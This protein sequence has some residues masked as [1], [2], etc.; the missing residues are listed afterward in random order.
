MRT[1]MHTYLEQVGTTLRPGRVKNIEATL[2]EFAGFATEH[3]PS[4]RC[5]ADLGRSHVEAY[6]C[7]WPNG[8]H[9][10]AVRCTV[11]QSRT[12]CALRGFFTRLLEWEIPDAP[13][14]IPVLASDMP[15]PDETL[16]RFLDDA[17]C[18][19]PPAPT[20][21]RSCG[22]RSSSSPAPWHAQG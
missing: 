12:D 8:Q 10:E 17:S 3:D 15:I 1:T 16:P 7:C 11:T 19:R 6:K 5:V 22:S 4:A 9:Y 18:C 13:T 14:K 2:R 21:T 20:T